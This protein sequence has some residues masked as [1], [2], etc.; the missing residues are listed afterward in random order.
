MR[1]RLVVAA[2]AV[3]S[4]PCLAAAGG[5]K[6]DFDKDYDFARVKTF[7]TKI[8]TAWGNSISERRVTTEITEVLT[9]KGWSPAT[10]DEA[11]VLVLVH[12]AGDKQKS[13]D[14]FV[15]GV[16]SY[17]YLHAGGASEVGMVPTMTMTTTESPVET[18][19]VDI[20]DAKSKSLT[21]RGTAIVEVSDSAEKNQKKIDKIAAKMFKDF[22]P[23]RARK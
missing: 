18:L 12:G 5:V 17:G 7:A 19:V 11:D 9:A 16:R 13:V 14:F 21:F 20:V 22:P 23:G 6:R 15:N 10:E 1:L 8:G 4:A 2:L 3:A